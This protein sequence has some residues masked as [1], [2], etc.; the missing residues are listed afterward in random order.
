MKLFSLAA[1]AVL[2]PFAA[3][4]HDGVAAEDA[5]ARSTNPKSGAVFMVLDNHRDVDCTLIGIS[6]DVAERV[7][8][9]GHAESDGMATMPLLGEGIAIPAGQQHVLGRAGD[10]VMLMGIRKPLTA[11]D[12]FALTLNFGECGT[13]DIDVPLDNDRA[14]AGDV[15]EDH[16][17]HGGG[18]K[19]D[20][21]SG[22]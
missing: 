5:Y 13:V 19:T 21:H 8:L 9:H 4:A 17:A 18:A 6:S 3:V 15:S 10:H 11:G 20:E 14:A 2:V 1:A 7:E 22:H 16:T 12:T